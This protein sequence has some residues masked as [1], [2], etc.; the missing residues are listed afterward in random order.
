MKDRVLMG[1]S[2]GKDSAMALWEIQKAGAYE[3]VALLTTVTEGYDRVSM[4]GVRR[5]LLVEQA[6]AIGL[7][8]REVCIPP[9]ASNAEYEAR[10]EDALRSYHAEGVRGVVFGDIFLQD[11]RRYREQ[12][13]ARIGMSALFPLWQRDTREMVRAFWAAGFRAVIVCVDLKVLDASFLGRILDERLLNDLPPSVDPCGENG[14]FHSF[15]FDGPIF[16]EPVSFVR[17]EVVVRGEFGF[18]DL[19]PVA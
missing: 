6:R 2:G 12:N 17:G 15:V 13:L 5:T 3:V 10:M 1:W 14:E 8:L 7:P 4:H 18:C 11:I 19:L 9:N 16:R